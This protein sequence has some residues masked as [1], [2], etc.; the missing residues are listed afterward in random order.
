MYCSSA[1]GT[2]TVMRT[3]VLTSAFTNSDLPPVALEQHAVVAL[4]KAEVACRG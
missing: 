2:T 4:A 1:F 3:F